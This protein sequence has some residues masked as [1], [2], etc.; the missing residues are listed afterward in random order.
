MGQ[1][2]VINE[3]LRPGQELR[4]EARLLITLQEQGS[5]PRRGFT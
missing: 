3:T 4:Q 2:G 1:S 5:T